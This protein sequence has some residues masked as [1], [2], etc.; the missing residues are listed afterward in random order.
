MPIKFSL[1]QSILTGVICFLLEI[2][3]ALRHFILQAWRIIIF[4]P[5]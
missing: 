5:Y 4:T 1:G 2:K 3:N